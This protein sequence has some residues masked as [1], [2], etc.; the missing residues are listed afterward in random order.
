MAIRRNNPGTATL[1][2]VV[3]LPELAKMLGSST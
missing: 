1:P 2:R 3:A